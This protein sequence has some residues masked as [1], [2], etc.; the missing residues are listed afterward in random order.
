MRGAWRRGNDE[1][2]G[3]CGEVIAYDDEVKPLRNNEPY[4]SS[5]I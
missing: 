4:R 3:E 1:V 2:T 5:L